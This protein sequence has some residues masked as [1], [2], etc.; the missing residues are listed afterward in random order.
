MLLPGRKSDC[1][2][3]FIVAEGIYRYNLSKSI[4][5][6]A[7]HSLETL[8][9]LLVL[10][11]RCLLLLMLL[12]LLQLLFCFTV[13]SFRFL[14]FGFVCSSNHGTILDLAR[15]VE[16]KHKYFF[17][18]IVDETMSVGVSCQF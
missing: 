3:R 14:H 18:L 12:S 15:V 6:R 17:R 10:L 8:F 4:I 11:F 2:R 13:L 1:Q 9:L 16:L 5:V 7:R